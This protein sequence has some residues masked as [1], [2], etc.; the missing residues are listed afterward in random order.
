M[1]G[2]HILNIEVAFTTCVVLKGNSEHQYFQLVRV[3]NGENPPKTERSMLLLLHFYIL[4][5]RTTLT[6]A[7]LWV[8]PRSL[9]LSRTTC[10]YFCSLV[11]SA[12]PC[13]TT[14]VYC[15]FLSSGRLVSMMLLTRS[16]VQGMRSAAINLA[17]SLNSSQR[18]PFR[19]GQ[20]GQ[21]PIEEVNRYS[22]GFG[23]A[24]QPYNPIALQQLLVSP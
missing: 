22:K 14:S 23:H 13:L 19:V 10:P 1:G 6:V 20:G 2:N 16:M 11:I 15:L 4:C 21:I 12:S 5:H 17:R 18:L 9:P 24:F 8:H 7:S 3:T